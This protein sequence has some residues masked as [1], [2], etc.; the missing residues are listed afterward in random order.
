MA[1][2]T[3]MVR[4]QSLAWE[5]AYAVGVANSS[6]IMHIYQNVLFLFNFIAFWGCTWGI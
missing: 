6:P 3:A 1:Q 4:G 2:V 5:L